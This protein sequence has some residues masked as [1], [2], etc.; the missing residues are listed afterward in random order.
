MKL[1][2][3][4]TKGVI[5]ILAV[6]CVACL[7]LAVVVGRAE[8]RKTAD[9]QAELKT[10]D[11]DLLTVTQSANELDQSEKDLAE[12]TARLSHLVKPPTTNDYEPELVDAITKLA[13]ECGALVL[14]SVDPKE[15]AVGT[16]SP[17]TKAAK[18][19]TPLAPHNY[20]S[21]NTKVTG[22]F[23]NVTDFIYR[24]CSLSKVV[25]V[26][27]VDLTPAGPQEGSP[28]TVTAT[29]AMTAYIIKDIP[30]A[31]TA[32]AAMLKDLLKAEKKYAEAKKEF[33]NLDILGAA[34]V[35]EN[36]EK[37]VPG[38]VFTSEGASK[39]GVKIIAAPKDEKDTTLHKLSIDQ[40]E[41]LMDETDKVAFE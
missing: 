24:L 10:V 29:L 11:D 16:P 25:S 21:V 14:V 34:G 18:K 35:T 7:G 1:H 33:T 28:E 19:D 4:P 32:A 39:D 13:H 9:K 17:A 36:D 30:G 23:H 26:D 12:I 8:A 6:L 41:K 2:L 5:I 3:E 20:L 31:T 37:S 22:S 15:G 38:Y 40:T 27:K